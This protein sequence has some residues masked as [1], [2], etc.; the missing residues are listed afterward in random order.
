M[1]QVSS[2]GL[3]ANSLTFNSLASC[4]EGKRLE[5]GLGMGILRRV[6]G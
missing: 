3:I 1:T 5:S 4:Q 2:L 6:G